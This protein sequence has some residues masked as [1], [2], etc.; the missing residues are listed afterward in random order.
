MGRP[1]PLLGNRAFFCCHLT[2][3]AGILARLCLL[4]FKRIIAPMP[5][6]DPS[7]ANQVIQ[8]NCHDVLERLPDEAFIQTAFL[9]P[10]YN[11]GLDYG[12][13][14]QADRLPA[15]VYLE[16]IQSVTRECVRRL[17]PTG[18]LWFLCP[19][20]WADQIGRMLTTMLPR[21]NRIIWRE[22]FGQY[23]ESR[24]P[25]GHRH[26]FWHVKDLKRSPFHT[27]EIRVPSQ[28]MQAGDKRAAG[29]RVPDDVWEIPRLVGNARERFGDHPCQ[30]PEELLRRVILSSTSEGDLVVDPMAGTGTTL[31]VAQC[32]NRRYLGIEEQAAFIDLIRKRLR[33]S[34]QTTLF[35]S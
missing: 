33:Q 24:F 10:P 21:R 7:P 20:Q 17:N 29:P 30:L 12:S 15:D 4:R 1:R 35:G 16:R 31:R 34:Y 28:R 27:D 13:G 22:T 14:R 9:D 18:S 8:G 3:P 6:T 11:I 2:S 23:N 19:E 5:L 25:S 32:L 26:L